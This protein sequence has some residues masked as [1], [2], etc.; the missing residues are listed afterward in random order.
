MN[1]KEKRKLQRHMYAIEEVFEK[2][3]R[4]NELAKKVKRENE[5]KKKR[6]VGVLTAIGIGIGTLTGYGISKFY[7][8][9]TRIEQQEEKNKEPI[10]FKEA[11]SL[12]V[13]LEDFGNSKETMLT[14]EAMLRKIEESKGKMRK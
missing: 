8:E 9:N 2:R 3:Q 12:G 10:T 4:D 6:I 7:G 14:V 13:N 5:R 1:N 11:H